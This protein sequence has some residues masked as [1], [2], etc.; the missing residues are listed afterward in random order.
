MEIV[1]PRGGAEA[2]PL[3]PEL[4]HFAVSSS[5]FVLP[6]V[7]PMAAARMP[8][9]S[10]PVKKAKETVSA[11]PN[12][13]KFLGEPDRLYAPRS[14]SDVKL[15]SAAA[16]EYFT[17]RERERGLPAGASL[18]KAD[19]DANPSLKGLT[20]ETARTRDLTTL[21]RRASIFIE[22]VGDHPLDQYTKSDIDFYIHCLRFLPPTASEREITQAGGW[23]NYFKSQEDLD[24]GEPVGEIMNA[25]TIEDGYLAG[26]RPIFRS[27][28]L[29][30]RMIDPFAL[31]RREYKKQFGRPQAREYFSDAQLRN[32][33]K[34][35]IAR[36]SL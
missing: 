29:E 35:G 31:V 28:P 36:G 23:R 21:R 16:K 6:P 11:D 22:L 7:T 10:G 4:K 3:R 1:Q 8:I 18:P 20:F 15:F 13:P 14:A 25:K 32:V 24:S 27:N 17:K 34:E 26:I 5:Q 12:Q 30:D 33:V 19:R 9:Q 2:M